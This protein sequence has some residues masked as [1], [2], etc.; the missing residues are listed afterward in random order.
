VNRRAPLE[1][2]R[3]FASLVLRVL[4]RGGGSK[5]AL[6]LV[7]V[8]GLPAALQRMVERGAWEEVCPASWRLIIR[9]AAASH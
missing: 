4:V 3:V 2:A 5:Q 7:R 1:Q 6:L 8:G 9:A